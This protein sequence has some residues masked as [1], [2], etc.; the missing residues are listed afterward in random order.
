APVVAKAK[1][2]AVAATVD[3]TDLAFVDKS[4]NVRLSDGGRIVARAA[5]GSKAAAL[6]AATALYNQR[7]AELDRL[8][9]ELETSASSLAT[10]ED[11]LAQLKNDLRDQPGLGDLEA[12]DLRFAALEA[13]LAEKTQ[14]QWQNKREIISDLEALATAQPAGLAEKIDD[15]TQT[16]ATAGSAGSVHDT[17]LEKR[18]AAALEAASRRLKIVTDHPDVLEDERQA[19]MDDLIDLMASE[20]RDNADAQLAALKD[21][22]RQAGGNENQSANEQF[23]AMT[24]AIEQDAASLA[25]EA[26]TLRQSIEAETGALDQAFTKLSRDTNA[27]ADGGELRSL[28]RKVADLENRGGHENRDL[29]S[30]L[31]R[32]LDELQWRADREI[33]K[34]KGQVA[35]LVDDA[36]K[37]LGEAEKI[38]ANIATLKEWRVVEDGAKAGLEQAEK[39]VGSLKDLGRV[40]RNEV[41]G[42]SNDLRGARKAL[43]EARKSFFETLD[44]NRET[45]GYKKRAL[46]DRLSFPPVGAST[47]ELDQHVDAVMAD[48]KAAGSAGRDQDQALWEEFQEIRGRLRGLREEASAAEREDYG[49]RLADAFTRKRELSYTI[50]DEIRM[51]RLVLEKQKDPKFEKEL[52]RKERR[53]EDLRKDLSDIQRKLGKISKSKAERS[54]EQA[55]A[56]EVTQNEAAGTSENAS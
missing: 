24:A 50:E 45:I 11:D 30:A 56:E 46:I 55:S 9:A 1:P 36:R 53:L 5:K 47:K 12:L 39:A 20:D 16:W 44:E 4:G 49:A 54:P 15:L 35:G 42:L 52:R 41:E 25:A 37:H 17:V 3:Q 51:G 22:W 38:P 21:A 8:E 48:W 2:T 27:I 14:A 34:R 31:R 40:A 19:V 33:E 28:G 23:Q 26:E 6:A 10:F 29:T 43:N 32:R 7:L 18:Y 13:A